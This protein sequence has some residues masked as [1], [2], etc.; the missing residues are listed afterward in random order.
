LFVIFDDTLSNN[1]GEALTM[2]IG[3]PQY[4]LFCAKGA[5]IPLGQ[6]RYA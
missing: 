1:T 4:F 5:F 3:S 6:E 2:Y